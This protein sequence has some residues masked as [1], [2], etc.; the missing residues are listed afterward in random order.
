MGRRAFAPEGTRRWIPG[1]DLPVVTASEPACAGTPEQG[2]PTG[3][4]SPVASGVDVLRGSEPGK[5]A[6][7]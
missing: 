7:L 1:L 4:D 3:V 5:A 6:E 2:L